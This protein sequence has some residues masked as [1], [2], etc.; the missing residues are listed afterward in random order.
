MQKAGGIVALI[1]GISGVWLA[2]IL[3]LLSIMNGAPDEVMH[4]EIMLVAWSFLILLFAVVTIRAKGKIPGVLVLITALLGPT[5]GV[6]DSIFFLTFMLLAAL[7]GVL[8]LIGARN[9]VEKLKEA[10][11]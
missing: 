4:S 8:A 11:D 2:S 3:V 10:S 7:G 1:A 6:Q 9:A 5:V